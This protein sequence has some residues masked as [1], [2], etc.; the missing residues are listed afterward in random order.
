M[1]L[2]QRRHVQLNQ[3]T[4]RPRIVRRRKVQ[5]KAVRPR[6]PTADR[7]AAKYQALALPVEGSRAG[8]VPWRVQHVESHVAAKV[9]LVAVFQL[10]LDAPFAPEQLLLKRLALR[11]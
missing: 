3:T 7:V 4:E 6:T 1:R 9:Y 2:G 11:N 5:R 10:A 8:R